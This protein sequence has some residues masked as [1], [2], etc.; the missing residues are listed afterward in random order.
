MKFS[1]MGVL[2]FYG[3]ALLI[4]GTAVLVQL[5]SA[6]VLALATVDSSISQQDTYIVVLTAV[7]A[8]A[9]C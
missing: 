6:D 9:M 1:T 4:H 8:C 5:C 3:S 2:R 7:Q